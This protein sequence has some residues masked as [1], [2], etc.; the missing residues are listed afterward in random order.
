M[1]IHEKLD[2]LIDNSQKNDLEW[3]DVSSPNNIVVT[4]DIG[5]RPT[6]ILAIRHNSPASGALSMYKNGITFHASLPGSTIGNTVTLTVTDT[7]FTY[8][9]TFTGSDY[10][11]TYT[12]F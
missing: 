3:H 2:Y 6:F 5:Y 12:V 7:G 8:R 10:P 9:Q 11:L 4:V 1:T